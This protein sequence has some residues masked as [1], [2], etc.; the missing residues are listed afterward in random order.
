MLPLILCGDWLWAA[1]LYSR[2]TMA[3]FDAI[4]EQE[5][6]QNARP[7]KGCVQRSSQE[8]G[9]QQTISDSLVRI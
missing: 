8:A 3:A 1:I 4:R 9:C 2:F 7:I 5:I 6:K